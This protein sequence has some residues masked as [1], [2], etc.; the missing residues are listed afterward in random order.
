VKKEVAIE[1]LRAKMYALMGATDLS[2]RKR[3]SAPGVAHRERDRPIFRGL[4][5]YSLHTAFIQPSYSLHTTFIQS[6]YSLDRALI[7]A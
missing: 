4:P 2:W 1:T 3:Q 5:S 7:E 6:S